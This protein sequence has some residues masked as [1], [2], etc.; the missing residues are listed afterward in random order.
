M[1]NANIENIVKIKKEI[2]ALLKDVEK[3]ENLLLKHV[4]NNTHNIIVYKSYLENIIEEYHTI[5]T[6]IY[7]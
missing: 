7:K 2:H 6:Q 4:Q 3:K 1:D 5:C